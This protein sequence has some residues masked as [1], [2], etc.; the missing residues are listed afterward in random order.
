[1]ALFHPEEHEGLVG[2]QSDLV[3][4]PRI[5]D[6]IDVQVL[7]GL[8]LE[9]RHID[10][11]EALVDLVVGYLLGTLDCGLPARAVVDHDVI[12]LKVLVRPVVDPE[13]G[14]HGLS[15]PLVMARGPLRGRFPLYCGDRASYLTGELLEWQ[16][17]EWL[18]SC[19]SIYGGPSES[20]R[21]GRPEGTVVPPPDKPEPEIAA[22]LVRRIGSGDSSAE[23]DLVRRYSRGLLFHLRRMTAD[24]Q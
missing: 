7:L 4:H 13:N 1:M 2:G 12:E 11:I 5:E 8:Q 16:V 18:R 3:Q 15:F 9:A 6:G 19:I 24:P 22:D 20:R 10:Q 17:L 21:S 23:E 14:S